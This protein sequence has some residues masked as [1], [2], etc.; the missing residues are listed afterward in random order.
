MSGIR[1]VWSL[2]VIC[3]RRMRSRFRRLALSIDN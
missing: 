1:A 3:T 2:E